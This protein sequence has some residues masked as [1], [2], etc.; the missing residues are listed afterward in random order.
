M[1]TQFGAWQE[2][3]ETDFPH[4]LSSWE[5][6]HT[7]FFGGNQSLLLP[8]S[9]LGSLRKLKWRKKKRMW[10]NGNTNLEKCVN[11]QIL[12]YTQ[13]TVSLLWVHRPRSTIKGK[14]NKEKECFLPR[15]EKSG[16]LNNV[17]YS[18]KYQ[19]S[20]QRKYI[21]PGLLVSPMEKWGKFVGNVRKP[22]SQSWTQNTDILHVTQL[23]NMS[24][25]AS[26]E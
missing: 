21:L 8:S 9:Q 19:Y 6:F 18:N 4:H 17:F 16:Y 23:A 5:I 12:H 20:V 25:T 22:P 13:I 1:K 11:M 14:L 24:P 15:R 3:R 7:E 2:A 26:V 10:G